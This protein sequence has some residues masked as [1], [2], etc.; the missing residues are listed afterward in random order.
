[1]KKFTL[2]SLFTLLF[3]QIGFSQ[4]PTILYSVGNYHTNLNL[5]DTTGGAYSIIETRTLTSDIGTVTGAYGLTL[6]NTNG[7]VY[8]L[9]SSILEDAIEGFRRLGTL[10]TLTAAIT[11]IGFSG[12]VTDLAMIG[13]TLYA[14]TGSYYETYQL[15]KINPVDATIT[16]IG[17]HISPTNGPSILY[18]QFSGKILKFDRDS[19]ANIILPDYS[20]TPLTVTSHPGEIHAAI[21]KND[22]VALVSNYEDLLEYNI[23]SKEF[24]S[25]TSFT[26]NIH[27]LLFGKYQCQNM[28]LTATTVDEIGGSD[29]AID[30]SVG[31]AAPVYA[32]DWDNDGVGDYDDTEDITGLT[33]GT[34]TISILDGQGCVDTET[35]TVNSQVGIKEIS[36]S[37]VTVY[38]NPTS[39][40]ITI[41]VEGDFTYT[42]TTING[43]VL[44]NGNATNKKTIDLST[45]TKGIYFVSINESTSTVKV[46]KN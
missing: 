15:V 44:E 40:K 30:L 17:E 27:G 14:T 33:A 29:G 24:T 9:Y 28:M 35:F 18:N 23:N 10:D 4:G 25:I 31:V 21:M 26:N 45:Y 13:D 7:I 20:E 41:E 34:Y 38:P 37:E 43:V 1:M 3:A 32:Y 22:S 5:L 8:I 16:E 19:V 12:S 36:N 2:L 6:D 11:D 46:I 42:L 39:N